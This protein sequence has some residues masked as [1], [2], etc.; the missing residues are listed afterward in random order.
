MMSMSENQEK[1]PTDQLNFRIPVKLHK[2]FRLAT[3]KN[4]TT[5]SDVIRDFIAKY[6]ADTNKPVVY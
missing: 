3:V 1:G 2:E 6:L 5:E 4:N